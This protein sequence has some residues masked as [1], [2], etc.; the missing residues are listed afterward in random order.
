MAIY[1]AGYLTDTHHPFENKRHVDLALQVFTDANIRSLYLGGDIADQFWCHGHGA[2]HPTPMILSSFEKERDAV[3]GFLNRIDQLW[4]D[5]P[6]HFIEGNHEN[7]FERWIIDKAPALFGVTEMRR[8]L[9]FDRRSKWSYYDYG[10][11]QLVRIDKTN[12]F[13]KHAPKGS[14]ANTI[15]NKAACNL[16][17]GHVHRVMDQHAVSADGRRLQIFSPGW[18]GDAR[19]DKVF[20]YVQG[21]HDWQSG[22]AIIWIDDETHHWWIQHIQIKNNRCVFNGKVYG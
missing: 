13:A 6:K 4:P 22:F 15:M 3:N 11:R 10:P 12:L 8:I 16:I 18:L 2:K 7:R 21:H 17:F 5:I 20:G 19:H 1:A 14:S 9:E